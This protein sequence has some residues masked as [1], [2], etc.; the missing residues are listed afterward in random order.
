MIRSAQARRAIRPQLCKHFRGALAARSLRVMVIE[1]TSVACGESWRDPAK[2]PTPRHV[3]ISWARRLK[4]VFGI[5]IETCVRCAGTLKIIASIEEP[6]LSAKI[7]SH[8]QRTASQQ[9]GPELPLG[10]RAPAAPSRLI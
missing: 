5:E 4:R 3:A 1:P 2:P 10:A 9:Y 7:L 6:E 8:L